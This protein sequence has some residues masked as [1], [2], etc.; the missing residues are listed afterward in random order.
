MKNY[1]G[2]ALLV[3]VG[4]GFTATSWAAISW[5]SRPTAGDALCAASSG[6]RR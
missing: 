3:I 1:L 5:H 2:F 4:C 6:K